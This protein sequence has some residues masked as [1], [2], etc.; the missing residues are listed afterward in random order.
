MTDKLVQIVERYFSR[1]RDEH[2][3]G[4]GTDERSYYPALAELLNAL[5]QELKPK[6][7]CL[8]DL[9]NTGAGHPDFGLYNANQVQKGE[10]RKG[11]PPERGVIEMK[12]VDDETWLT[13]DTKQVSKYFG[14][15]RLVIVSNL[16]DFLIV[17]EGP[18]GK[19]TKLEGFRLVPTAKA[20]WEMVATPRKSAELV[21]RAFGEYLRRALTQSVALREPKDVAWFLASYARDALQR[22]EAAGDLPALAN[23]R[24]SLEEAL[25]VT[26]DAEKGEHFFRSTLVQTLFYG[27]FSAWALWAR[28][29]PRS[30]SKFQWKLATW[31]LTVPF[32]RTLFDQIASPT[33]LQPLH[34]IE[35][36]DWTAATLNRI[37]DI[38]FFKRFNDS[39]AVQFFYEPFLEAFD[40]ELRKELGVWYTPSEVVTYM[41][42]RVDKALREDLKIEDGLASDQV[43]ILDPCCGTG[44]F[45]AA[46]LKRIEAS[47]EAKGFGALKGQMV[48][49]A[50]LSRVFGFEIMPAPFVV[51]HLQV[52]LT[53][54]AMNAT[55][56]T[57]TERAG[58]F[59]TNALTGWEP[60][61]TKPLPFPELEEERSRADKVKQDAPILVVIGNPPYNGFAGVNEG[62]EERALTDA[63]KRPNKVRRPEGQGLNDLYARFFRM[64]ER[65]IV[66]KLIIDKKDLLSDEKSFRYEDGGRGIVCFISNYSW[67]DGLSF[68]AMR[69]RYLEAY[70]AIRID[71]LNGDKYKTG[72]TTPEGLP[73]PSIFSTEH[74]RE[75][76][77]VGTAIT[78]LVRK[79]DHKP[80]ASV[81][82][83]HLWGAQ[84]RQALLDSAETEPTSLYAPV[85]PPLELGLPFVSTVVGAGYFDW[86]SLPHIFP[87]SFPGVK[88]SRDE[89]LVDIDRH[90]LEQRIA[91]YFDPK[92][93]NE[94]I[95]VRYAQVMTA[96]DRF[97]PAATRA[98][99]LK[100]GVIAESI[101]RYAYRP[102]DIRWLY[103]E[104]ET[105]LLDE[106]RTE[107]RPHSFAGNDTLAAQQKP[108]GEWQSSQI[109]QSIACLDLIDRGSS[110]FPMAL[111]DSQTNELRPNLSKPVYDYLVN[112][113]IEDGA[114]F[115]SAVAILH[116][117]AYRAEN[118][119]ALRMDW[120][121][122][123]I[124][125]EASRLKH[126]AALGKSL[127][128]ILNPETSASGIS[129]GALRP[130]LRVFGLPAKRGGKP[131]DP[132]DLS[133]TAGWGSTQNAVSGAIVMP[134]RGLTVVR[135]YTP[136]ERKALEA[137]AQAIGMTLDELLALIGVRTLDVH[138]NADTF[139]S[140]VP[141]KVWDY[142]L[143]GYQVIK[144][145]LSY[146]E[147]V[148]LGRAL[149]PEEATYVSEMVRRIAAILMM[150]PVLDANFRACAADAQTYEEL[151]LSRDAARERKDAKTLKRGAS[152][153][154]TPATKQ[155]REAEKARGKRKKKPTQV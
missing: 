85:A 130:A 134:G 152:K 4:A 30:S 153:K 118:E 31:H 14:A 27:V 151:G 69:E 74:N 145:W 135:D 67:L 72:K 105:K 59:L 65:R 102:F 150:A 124:P 144:K 64:A 41:V 114:A 5:G 90:A 109:V 141:E 155:N 17:G 138:I 29:T 7:L 63:Y 107:Y 125:G 18:T 81:E 78:T 16:R 24:T 28:E 128:T 97:D 10:P 2:G 19:A 104:P 101:I 99:L 127:A 57:S 149:R 73:D 91:E 108:R 51:A 42:A 61:V 146:R 66:Q 35:V 22:V 88:T 50:A 137:E 83:R 122:V 120:P 129:S 100:R 115:Y 147:Q 140:N 76:I 53:L 82:F 154:H 132:V 106:K 3:L 103:W 60:H 62:K 25:G 95:R 112:R 68:T 34:L 93:S 75:G 1:L 47:Y 148:V 9:A 55:L 143:G 49:K 12:G 142:S 23:V 87:T 15:Y 116:A 89:F 136:L 52:G 32:I 45:L 84:K 110:N 44:A 40:P 77:Q 79:L 117:P 96:S 139:W 36:L 38:E 131:L 80:V 48:K 71:C 39:D 37:D 26:F 133:L 123:P 8:S 121:R 58:I 92:F 126:S 33:H 46:V 119:G 56:D 6:I 43:Y 111:K 86:I 70:D 98:A 13:A 94:D 20:F 54:H 113:K 21:G 11:Q